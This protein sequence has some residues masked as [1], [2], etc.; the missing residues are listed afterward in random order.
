MIRAILF[1][2]ILFSLVSCTSEDSGEE[3]GY[4]GLVGRWI[5]ASDSGSSLLI[6]QVCCGSRSRV[7]GSLTWHG[8]DLP[9]GPASM[10][11]DYSVILP[12]STSSPTHILVLKLDLNPEEEGAL[13]RLEGVA[14][15]KG[16]GYSGSLPLSI[17]SLRLVRWVLVP[18]GCE[19][20]GDG[21]EW[22]KDR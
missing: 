13:C 16:V 12:D 17:S 8:A 22:V 1:G 7:K 9:L 10:V 6:T 14:E 3:N 4:A 5:T 20:W 21:L 11:N 2:F 15:S 18:S 19:P